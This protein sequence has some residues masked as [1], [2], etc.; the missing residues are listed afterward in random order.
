MTYNPT[1]HPRAPKGTPNGG[2]FTVKPGVGVDNDLETVAP[3][4]TEGFETVEPEL[5]Y[6]LNIEQYRHYPTSRQ[7]VRQDFARLLAENNP[8]Y[9]EKHML[10]W[11]NEHPLDMYRYMVLRELKDEYDIVSMNPRVLNRMTQDLQQDIE[12]NTTAFP[13]ATMEDVGTHAS[14]YLYD[15]LDNALGKQKYGDDYPYAG[16]YDKVLPDPKTSDV[17]VRGYSG[18]SRTPEGNALTR[19]SVTPIFLTSEGSKRV[20]EVGY[21][22]AFDETLAASVSTNR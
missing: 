15:E 18:R 3:D 13:I 14:A 5:P 20:A 21:S 10:R 4:P 8:D 22:Q 16:D 17:T 11:V 2:Q 1:D 9:T 12:D 19:A 7:T 6:E